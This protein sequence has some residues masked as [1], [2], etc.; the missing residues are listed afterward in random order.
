MKEEL[1]IADVLYDANTSTGWN[2][3]LQLWWPYVYDFNIDLV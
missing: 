1:G 2:S 3:E